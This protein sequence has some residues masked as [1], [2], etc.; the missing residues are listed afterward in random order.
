M[1]K[2]SV[3]G[4]LY[5]GGIVVVIGYVA[6]LAAAR[7]LYPRLLYPAPQADMYSPGEGSLLTLRANDG[8][9]VHATEFAAP[10][11]APVIVY[12]HGNGVVMGD[13]L[14]M[15]RE[16]A[17]RGLGVV[18]CEYRGYGL[19]SGPLP[20]ENGFY[21][22]AEA[23]FTTLASRGIGP[24]R[25]VLLGESLGTGV[26]AEMAVRGW[27]SSLVLITPYTSILDM[28]AHVQS[29]L[30]PRWVMRERFDTLAKAPHIALPAF[31]LHGKE[32]EIVPYAMAEKVASALPQ[33]H[34][35]T[36]P[37]GH[38][39]DLFLGTGV[40]FFDEIKAFVLRAT[41]VDRPL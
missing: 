25:I 20:D 5:I 21:Q 13:D 7:L 35:V 29:L 27:G 1:K 11:G 15:A 2:K 31:V 8:V 19:S 40:R 41:Q 3:L 39:N 18:L 33:A 26:A 34:L 38:H 14:W 28:G 23:V 6:L 22:D 9:T 16:F 10:G 17:R 37:G 12:F 36:V 30:P 4:I 32:D 24:G